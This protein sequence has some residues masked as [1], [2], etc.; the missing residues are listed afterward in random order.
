MKKKD[1]TEGICVTVDYLSSKSGLEERK[2]T[3]RAHAGS[4]T[5]VLS[6]RW[7][8]ISLLPVCYVSMEGH[9]QVTCDPP[10]HFLILK[11]QRKE[12]TRTKRK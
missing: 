8:R 3:G 12:L 1:E 2:A 6:Q 10:N 7:T 4:C 11:K 5:L 9:L